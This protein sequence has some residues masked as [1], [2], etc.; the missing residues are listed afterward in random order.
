MPPPSAPHPSAQAVPVLNFRGIDEDIAAVP[1]PP[2]MIHTRSAAR[3]RSLTAQ[4]KSTMPIIPESPLVEK[5]NSPAEDFIPIIHKRIPEKI[6]TKNLE[7]PPTTPSDDG[8]TP[9]TPA[10]SM[11]SPKL[12]TKIP[13]LPSPRDALGIPISKIKFIT[14]TR[15]KNSPIDHDDLEPLSPSVLRDIDGL[16]VPVQA[17]EKPKRRTVWGV[18]EGWWELGLLERGKSLRRK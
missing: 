2:P 15:S 4:R 8:Y 1:P 16:P 14:R 6:Q 18:L 13:S 12:K 17:K 11:F 5:S 9:I 7:V 10:P 3:G